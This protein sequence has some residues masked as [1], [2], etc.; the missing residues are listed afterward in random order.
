MS[1]EMNLKES[2][3]VKEIVDN[4]FEDGKVNDKEPEIRKEVIE[5]LNLIQDIYE[6]RM[7]EVDKKELTQDEE[8]IRNSLH[9]YFYSFAPFL[10]VSCVTFDNK[11]ENFYEGEEREAL[12]KPCKKMNDQIRERIIV[13]LD[14]LSEITPYTVGMFNTFGI[15]ENFMRTGYTIFS[16]NYRMNE[17]LEDEKIEE[18]K[19]LKISD[20]LWLMF[21][22]TE[23]GNS[24]FLN[25][26]EG[27][28]QN[29]AGYVKI[30]MSESGLAV[31][32]LPLYCNENDDIKYL[33]LMDTDE[34]LQ[35]QLSD[36]KE[37]SVDLEA[38]MNI[39]NLAEEDF[40]FKAEYTNIVDLLA[41]F[42]GF[43]ILTE[44]YKETMAQLE[45]S[46]EVEDP[47]AELDEDEVVKAIKEKES[48]IYINDDIL[49]AFND[50]LY[51]IFS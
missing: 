47:E 24:Y 39:I 22:S 25:I 14:R 42:Y 17:L 26:M 4:I 28:R 5:G 32:F 29:D 43:M 21:S 8:E 15:I 6:K 19:K 2:E 49:V 11:F 20:I 48:K 40:M 16:D 18:Q 41:H 3:E 13:L 12:P 51:T 50:Y 23:G 33:F 1:N 37:F 34:K 36:S 45:Y 31:V 30:P 44:S 9:E 46:S 7:S 10:C 27:L 38:L 35:K